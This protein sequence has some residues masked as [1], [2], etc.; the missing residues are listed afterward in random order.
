MLHYDWY[1]ISNQNVNQY[2]SV[3]RNHFRYDFHAVVKPLD[4]SVITVENLSMLCYTIVILFI[5]K[6][7]SKIKINIKHE[8]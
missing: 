6:I 1:P 5:R 8:L 7:I 4:K 3:K 2:S